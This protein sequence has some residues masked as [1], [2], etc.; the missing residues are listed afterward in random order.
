MLKKCLPDLYL[1]SAY[2]LPISELKKR[3]IRVLMCDVDNTL[4]PH[5]EKKMSIRLELF[6]KQLKDAGIEVVF[7]SNN[8][9]K[10]LAVLAKESGIET[11]SFACKPLPFVF[12]RLM[13][14]HHIQS[15]ELAVMGDQLFTDILGGNLQDAFTILCEPMEKRDIFYTRPVRMIEDCVFRYFHKKGYMTK[16]DY[17]ETV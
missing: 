17:H 9:K 8:T 2:A 16:G 3:G 6:I 7:V 13:K 1:S 12:Y 11:H 4:L 10:R 15:K 14:N 5:D